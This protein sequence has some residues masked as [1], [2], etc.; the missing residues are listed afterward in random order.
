MVTMAGHSGRALI[1]V[2]ALVVVGGFHPAEAK[3]NISVLYSFVG[4]S[5]GHFPNTGLI[6]DNAGNL[7]GGAG[8][9]DYNGGVIFQVSQSGEETVLHSF[10]DTGDGNS[11]DGGLI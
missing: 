2:L 4:G 10:G 7:I 9:G 3:S 5:G 1:A 11:P 6:T 8:G